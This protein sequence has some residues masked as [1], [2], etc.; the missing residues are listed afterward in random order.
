M[1]VGADEG[2]T[3]P[4]GNPGFGQDLLVLGW[5]CWCW[6]P[7]GR[8]LLSCWSLPLLPTCPARLADHFGCVGVGVSAYAL[9]LI[10]S[11]RI[12]YWFLMARIPYLCRNRKQNRHMMCQ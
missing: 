4:G 12:G 7:L 1:G 3:A 11:Q 10:H 6:A 2:G 9:S 5:A 8:L